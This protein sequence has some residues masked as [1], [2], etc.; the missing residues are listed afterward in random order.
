V[1]DNSTI[2]IIFKSPL[3]SKVSQPELDLVALVFAEFVAEISGD[4]VVDPESPIQ[5]D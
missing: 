3:E 4:E 5:R 2:D 1:I